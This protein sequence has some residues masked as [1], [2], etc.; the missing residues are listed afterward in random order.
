[1]AQK[2]K[3]SISQNIIVWIADKIYEGIKTLNLDFE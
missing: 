3:T 1:M 2:I